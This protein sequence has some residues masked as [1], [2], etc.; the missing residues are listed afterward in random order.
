MRNIENIN[1]KKDEKS[2]FDRRRLFHILYYVF[3]F[4]IASFLVISTFAYIVNN[5]YND[6][7]EELAIEE[8]VIKDISFE[9]KE[10]VVID[11]NIDFKSLWI[12]NHDLAF[13]KDDYVCQIVFESGIIN[14]PVVQ[15]PDNNYYLRRDFRTNEYTMEGPIFVECNCNVDFDSNI[16]LFG[17]NAPLSQDPNREVLFSSLHLLEEKNN[18]ESNKTI[19]L[20]YKDRV[21]TYVITNVYEAKIYEDGGNQYLVDG[22]PLYYL[23]NYSI[24]EFETYYDAAKQRTIYETG[25]TLSHD[26][27]L[28]TLQTCYEDRINKLIVLAKKIDSKQYSEIY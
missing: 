26:D 16:T 18:Y 7:I 1:N 19:Y 14:Q 20:A 5:Y 21:D 22:E 27:S 2:T 17:H 25:E 6:E 28:L 15:G 8:K 13:N 10:T 4:T 3:L 9:E 11:N 12:E 23:N 24:E